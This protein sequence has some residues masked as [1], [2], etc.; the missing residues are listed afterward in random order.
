MLFSLT[1]ISVEIFSF[2]MD[3]KNLDAGV[4]VKPIVNRFMLIVVSGSVATTI[5]GWVVMPSYW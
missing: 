1:S 2:L 4:F 3:S 5:G